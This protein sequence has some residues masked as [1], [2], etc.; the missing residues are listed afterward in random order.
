MDGMFAHDGEPAD[1][2]RV[3]G[4]TLFAVRVR[5]Y[6][7]ALGF[8]PLVRATDR[9][10][11]LAVLGIL[12]TAAF[13]VPAAVSAGT[14]VHDTGVRT[15]HEQAESRHSVEALVV[16]GVGLPT[17]LDTPA[18]V[19]AQWRE[20]TQTRTESVVSPA[21]IKAG[22]HMT[23]WLDEGGK[24]VAAPLTKGDA[25]LNAVAVGVTL[26]ISIVMSSVIVAYLIRR[27]LDRSRERSWERELQLLAHN[28]D[29]WANRHG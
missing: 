24:V 23:V 1:R 13:A 8:N 26:W 28:D 14:L 15:A 29:G 22:D 17:D 3:I 20:G 19:Q 10:E 21:T 12:V 2:R 18:Y 25:E 6:L 7:R 27:G 9:L 16:D 11:A 4:V 5:W